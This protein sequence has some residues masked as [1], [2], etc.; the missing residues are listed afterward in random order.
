MLNI[1]PILG[2]IAG[3]FVGFY[4]SIAVSYIFGRS[5]ANARMIET[6]MSR[7]WNPLL[8]DPLTNA[9]TGRLP[10]RAALLIKLGSFD[11]G[12][13]KRSLSAN[14]IKNQR[15]GFEGFMSQYSIR[16]LLYS[17]PHRDGW[18]SCLCN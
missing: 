16:C 11:Q 12:V 8:F 17:L 7:E 3:M 18:D 14:A 4:A 1:I 15:A 9:Q 13:P 6:S 2:T 10:D 5:V